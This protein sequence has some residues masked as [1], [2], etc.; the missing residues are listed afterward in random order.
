MG[1]SAKMNIL[2]IDDIPSM[3]VIIKNMLREIGFKNFTEAEDGSLA[4]DKIQESVDND[5][6]VK[7][8]ICDYNMPGKNGLDLYKNLQ[9]HATFKRIPFL[10]ITAEGEQETVVSLAKGGVRNLI[11]KPVSTKMLKDKI[12]KILN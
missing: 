12:A 2:I 7:F 1:L 8:I 11:V 9:E 4:M 10:M 5:D 6:P 3:R